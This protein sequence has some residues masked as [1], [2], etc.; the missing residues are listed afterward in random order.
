[1]KKS[2]LQTMRNEQEMM[3]LILSTAREDECIR[4]VIMNGSRVNP[5]TKPDRFQD[6]DIIY[7]VKDLTPFVDDPHWID[8]FGDR[9]IMQTPSLM[10]DPPPDDEFGFTY[11]M[12]FMDGNRIDLTLFSNR[13]YQ[14]DNPQ[15][16]H[17]TLPPL[18][19]GVP[20]PL[21]VLPAPSR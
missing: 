10:F 15:K 11:L 16:M 5:N 9:V 1:M 8:R 12:Q 4:A 3:D 13:Y 19:K 14:P 20:H 21:P 17:S 18:E 6:F 7:I 2:N